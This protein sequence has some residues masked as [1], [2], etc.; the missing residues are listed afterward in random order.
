MV[1][2]LGEAA[3]DALSDLLV[4]GLLTWGTP[5]LGLVLVVAALGVPL[6]VSILL[7]AAGAF[8]RQG[9]LET[10]LVAGV[11]VAGAVLGDALSFGLGRFAQG[12]VMQKYGSFILWRRTQR[13]FERFGGLTIFLTRFLLTS[14]ALPA[15]LVAGGSGYRF[16]RFILLDVLGEVLWVAIYGGAGYW[17][18]GQWESV[19]QLLSDAGGW[20]PGLILTLG[21]G[22]AFIK[23]AKLMRKS[24]RWNGMDTKEVQRLLSH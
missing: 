5:L 18:G 21:G 15:N 10:P 1:V 9:L 4:N 13:M 23:V 20:L 7:V 8:A 17:F 3:M 6:P 2:R 24:N 11:G 12:W 16:L 19:S 22:Y 14:L